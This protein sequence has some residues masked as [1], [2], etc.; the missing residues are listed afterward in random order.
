[1]KSKLLVAYAV[2]MHS[3]L[4]LCFM[5]VLMLSYLSLLFRE[6]RHMHVQLKRDKKA[7]EAEVIKLDFLFIQQRQSTPERKL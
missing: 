5:G 7:R 1:M 2:E 6:N 4:F 3:N